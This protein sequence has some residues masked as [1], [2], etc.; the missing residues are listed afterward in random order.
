MVKLLS[1]SKINLGL[2]I[3]ER[4][5]DGYHN[6]ETAFYPIPWNDILEFEPTISDRDIFLNTGIQ[7]PGSF[8]SNLIGKALKLLRN[9]YSFGPVKISLQKEVPFGAGLGAG[10]ANAAVTLKGLNQL[11]S[12][13]IS[14]SELEKMAGSLGADCAFFIKN[15]PVF[16]EGI[17]TN[18]S[19]IDL[20]FLKGKW[21]QVVWPGFGVNTAWAYSRIKP[22][23]PEQLT[24]QVLQHPNRWQTELVNDFESPIALTHPEI[25]FWK[26][27]FY[28]DGAFYAS[29]SGSGSAVFGLFDNEPPFIYPPN[30][31]VKSFRGML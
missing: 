25:T 20:G 21:I 5:S 19:P 31:S 12:L 13:G 17:G 18:F 22:S 29:M 23:K 16:A 8:E 27:Q 28:K 26:N 15:E 24:R 10:S 7:V 9:H 2:R 3:V 4:R 14:E 30:S 1:G 11:F 6:I